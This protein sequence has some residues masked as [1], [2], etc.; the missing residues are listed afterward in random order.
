MDWFLTPHQYSTGGKSKNARNIEA[1]NK[2]LR[3]LFVH[4]ARAVIWRD[5]TAERYF[6][7]WLIDLK[8]R[9]PFNVALVALANKLARMHGHAMVTHKAFEIRG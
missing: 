2:E 4:A 8:R 3:E 1:G 5:G 9:K 6:G 7:S